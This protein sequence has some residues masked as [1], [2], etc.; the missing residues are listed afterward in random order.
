MRTPVDDISPA[1]AS[2]PQGT[3]ARN[4]TILFLAALTIMAG[5]T[6]SPALPA[7][8]SHFSDSPQAAILT[9]LVLTVP[10]LFIALS[11]PFAG[12]LADRYGRRPVAIAAVVLYGLAG[13]SG[14][15]ADSLPGLLIG[16]A[17][18]GVAVAGVMTVA[19]ALV[20]DFFSGA[21][22]DRFMGLQAAFIGMG[23]LVFLTGGGLLAELH[24]RA[25]F[26]IYAI[27]FGLLPAIA[28]FIPEPVLDRRPDTASPRAASAGLFTIPLMAVFVAAVLNSIVFYLM[29]TQLPFHLRELG[30]AAP[31]LAGMALGLMTLASALMSFYYGRV[32]RHVSV[33]GVFAVGFALL[34]G[35]LGIVALA[36]DYTAVLPGA[37]LAGCAIGLVMPNLN[38]AAMGL[39]DERHRG[40]VAGMLTASI[41]FGQFIS[42]LIS[43]PLSAQGGYASAFGFGAATIMAA[44]LTAFTVAATR[45]RRGIA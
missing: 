35:G 30:T 32:R 2:H 23:G 20:G 43:Q 8:E 22:R 6:I 28:L 7:I 15:V 17:L 44:S 45:R 36:E 27:A 13:S 37:L 19:T 38:S 12:V 34:A 29:P 39:A 42:P 21:G 4:A 25:P 18:L 26:L 3:A 41:F 1:F 33:A 24:W 40:R 11:A 10:A 16:R 9:R 31:I 5:A 14:L